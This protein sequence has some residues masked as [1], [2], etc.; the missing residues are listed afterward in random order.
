M[1]STSKVIIDTKTRSDPS[2]TGSV[3]STIRSVPSTTG[4]VPSTTDNQ[5]IINNNYK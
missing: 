1:I 4:S 5:L 2:T 3:A